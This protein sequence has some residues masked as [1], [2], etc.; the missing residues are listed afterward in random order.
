MGRPRTVSDDDILSAALRVVTRLG[1][2]GATLAEVAA[3]AR[4]AAATLV[5][6][7]GSKR[8]LL[9]AVAARGAAAAAAPFEAAAAADPS[10]LGALVRALVSMAG[11][12]ATPEALANH[13][14]FFQLDLRDPDFSRL[15]LDHAEEVGRRIRALLDAA[16]A[17]GELEPCDTA[18]LARAV[19]VTY[20][21]SLV[22]WAVHRQGPVADAVRVDVGLVLAPFRPAR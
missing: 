19:E 9:L 14:A 8:G 3:E 13:L 2:D 20:N 10:P 11:F 18:R 7:F 1:P 4:L 21:G 15:A 6:R 16:R 17:A 22:T 12:A 5:Q